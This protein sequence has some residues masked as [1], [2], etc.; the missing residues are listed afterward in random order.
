MT[1]P[2]DQPP[3]EPEARDRDTD[4]DT[5]RGEPSDDPPLSPQ[6]EDAVRR[7]LA[8]AGG[9][10]P[11]PGE[12]ADR[13]DA[14]IASLAAERAAIPPISHAEGIGPVRLDAAARR[15]RNRGRL[16]L[17]AAA[18]TVVGVVGVGVATESGTDDLT[19]ADQISESGPA[20]NEPLD[21]DAPSESADGGDAGARKND[22]SDEAA[23]P[24]STDL[25]ATVPPVAP[26]V[27]PS[28]V[29]TDGPLREVRPDHLHEDLV[30]LQHVSLPDPSDADYSGT[31]LHAPE[32]FMCAPAP[33]GRGFL[34]AVEYDGRPAIVAFREPVGSTQAAEV[35]A[36]GTG[37][38][39]HST[40]LP[41]T[42]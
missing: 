20:R 29:A 5:G 38:V 28:R 16:L 3:D 26:Y 37:D 9:P 13:L 35:L 14:V 2:H 23:S 6:A 10:E 19:A 8:K 7:A 31:R 33:L 11:M 12:V 25:G 30:A 22:R 42:G 1:D 18:V 24:E 15:R 36:C 41:V 21:G 39:L 4:L 34:V 17:A 27:R 40:T 32:A